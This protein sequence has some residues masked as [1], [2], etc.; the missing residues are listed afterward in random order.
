MMELYIWCFNSQKESSTCVGSVSLSAIACT[1]AS[2]DTTTDVLFRKKERHRV[3]PSI[4]S[5][6][7]G[8]EKRNTCLPW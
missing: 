2:G 7:T 3:M 1:I 4:V 5:R 6:L 8:L